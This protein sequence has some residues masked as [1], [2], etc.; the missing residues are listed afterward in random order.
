MDLIE[1]MAQALHQH[2]LQRTKATLGDRSAYVGMSDIGKAASC[3]RSA[4]A[5]KLAEAPSARSLERQLRLNRGHWFESGMAEAFHFSGQPYLY[6]ARI[7]TVHNGISIRAHPDFIFI[8]PQ[9][10]ALVVELKSCGHLP[11]T[12][13]ASYEMQL[14]GQLGLLSS[15]WHKPCF[16]LYEDEEPVS[17]PD[18][19]KQ[20]LGF[21]LPEQTVLSGQI[22]C[23]SM[24]EAK[25]FGPYAP[26]GLMLSACLKLAGQIWNGLEEVRAGASLN[27]LPTATG[28][29]PLCDW[30]EWNADCPRFAG[31]AA[32]ELEEDLLEW[33][34]LKDEKEVLETR[35]QAME[36]QIRSACKTRKG[37][38]LTAESLRIRLISCEGKRSFDKDLLQTELARHLD[39]DTA[40]GVM[41]AAYKNGKPYD[42]LMVGNIN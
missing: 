36:E 14:F 15:L 1:L 41:A 38:W 18:L 22:L 42:R 12:V 9:G 17:F 26:N 23:V 10:E 40:C 16:S 4:V 11:D 39:A 32:P 30:C 13:Y 5:G 21:T 34:K 19:V 20:N 27:A 33:Q 24:N 7:E 2:G 25:V 31:I 6:Q 3:L 37:E 28:F 29:N 8:D 35:I